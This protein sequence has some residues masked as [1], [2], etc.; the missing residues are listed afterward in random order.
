MMAECK[1][2]R[3]GV[4]APDPASE[5]LAPSRQRS[6]RPARRA[7]GSRDGARVSREQSAVMFVFDD[8]AEELALRDRLRAAL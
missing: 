3:G 6:G 5:M 7:P 4:V 2:T 1:R 8:L